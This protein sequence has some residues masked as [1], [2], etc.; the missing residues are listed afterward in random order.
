MGSENDWNKRSLKTAEHFDKKNQ[1]IVLLICNGQH[2][3]TPLWNNNNGNGYR[4]KKC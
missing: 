4:Q 1:N 3:I 2:A